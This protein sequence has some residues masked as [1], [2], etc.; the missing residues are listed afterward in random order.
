MYMQSVIMKRICPSR[1]SRLSP[2]WL[3]G[4]SCTWSHD[5]RLYIYVYMIHIRHIY[6]IYIVICIYIIYIRQFA[7]NCSFMVNFILYIIYLFILIYILYIYIINFI[8]IYIYIYIYNK[9]NK[10]VK[11]QSI[12]RF[13]F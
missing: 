6:M 9:Q 7:I 12:H 13:R 1:P 8:Y 10:Y 11:T 5:V 3:C 4:N 2:Q